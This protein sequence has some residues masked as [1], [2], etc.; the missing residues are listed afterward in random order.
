VKVTGL[1]ADGADIVSARFPRGYL[2]DRMLILAL[3]AC[4]RRACQADDSLVL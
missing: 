4:I 2:E 3:R 1:R